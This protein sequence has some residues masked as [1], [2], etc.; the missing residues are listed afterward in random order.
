MK[1][2]NKRYATKEDFEARRAFCSFFVEINR[3]GLKVTEHPDIY[4]KQDPKNREMRLGGLGCI[5]WRSLG[6]LNM[7]S[8][9]DTTFS[10]YYT[11][12]ASDREQAK[13]G[14]I[15]AALEQH[16]KMIER[17][18]RQLE[19]LKGMELLYE[20]TVHAS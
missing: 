19:R 18:T 5:D 1:D 4:I 11:D 17:A 13:A 15:A 6:E 10:G 3:N 7:S 12:Y 20:R 8:M 9:C 2:Q 16:A 14:A